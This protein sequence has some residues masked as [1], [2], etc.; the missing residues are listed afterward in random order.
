MWD[1]ENIIREVRLNCSDSNHIILEDRNISDAAI[2]LAGFNLNTT[3]TVTCCHMIITSM[4]E[5]GPQ[6]CD[7]Y[8]QR[9]AVKG[10]YSLY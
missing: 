7:E 3:V 10:K 5:T 8:S 2:V 6:K 1:T 9:S 4:N